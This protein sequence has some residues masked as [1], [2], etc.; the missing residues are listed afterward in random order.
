MQSSNARAVFGAPIGNFLV[1]IVVLVL[2]GCVFERGGVS[3]IGPYAAWHGL[4][5]WDL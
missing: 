5:L 4:D 3:P 1:L 2:E